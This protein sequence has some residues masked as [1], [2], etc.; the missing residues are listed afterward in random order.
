MKFFVAKKPKD[1]LIEV[2]D[3]DQIGE[4]FEGDLDLELKNGKMKGSVQIAVKCRMFRPVMLEIKLENT[5][6]KLA[7]KME[8]CTAT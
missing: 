8:E 3:Y 2:F 7:N 6:K 5:E 4:S 1:M